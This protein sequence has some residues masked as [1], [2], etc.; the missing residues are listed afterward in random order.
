[1]S[2]HRFGHFLY[3]SIE[4]VGFSL[5]R[6]KIIKATEKLKTISGSSPNYDLF[7]DTSYGRTQTGATVPLIITESM[8]ANVQEGQEYFHAAMAWGWSSKSLTK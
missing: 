7:N 2:H 5:L 4:A 1:M 6:G 8:S 3:I